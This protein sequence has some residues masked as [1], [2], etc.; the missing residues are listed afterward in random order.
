MWHEQF[1]DR[2]VRDKCQSRVELGFNAFNDRQDDPNGHGTFVA[3]LAA[4][5]SFGV[6]RQA[7]I[8]SVRVLDASGEADLN[9]ILSGLEWIQSRVQEG[10]EG[11]GRAIVKY[12][13][14]GFLSN[15]N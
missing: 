1:L 14:V 6:A 3:A 8:V 9:T 10:N 13:F 12:E 11:N 5:N 4:G 2:S 15:S 7:H